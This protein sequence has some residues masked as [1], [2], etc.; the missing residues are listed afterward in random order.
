MNQIDL[1]CGI[2]Q[3]QAKQFIHLFSKAKKVSLQVGIGLERTRNGGS[4]IR[5]AMA[6]QLLS[7]NIGQLGQGIMGNYS[8]ALAKTADRL[9]RPDLL[10][11]PTRV[12]NLIDVADHILERTTKIPIKA[13]FIYNHN[14][15]ATHPD[16]N[17][18]CAA[19]SLEDVFIVGCDLSMTDSM[20]YA[21]IILPAASHFEHSEIYGA[22]G[23]ATIQH[24]NAVIDPVGEAWPN[25]EI[26]RQLS[27]RFGFDDDAFKDSD[28]ALLEQAFE[29]SRRPNKN[30]SSLTNNGIIMMQHDTHIWLSDMPKGDK[31]T[32]Y[33]E[34]LEQDYGYG[35]PRYEALVSSRPYQLITAASSQRTNAFFGGESGSMGLQMVDINPL[36]AQSLDIKTGRLVTL[37][38]HKGKVV[39]VANVTNDVKQ[40]I[41]S[42]DKGAW[43][44]ASPTAQNANALIDNQSKTD[45]GEGAA[46]YDTFVDIAL[47]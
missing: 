10:E 12:F 14:P 38:N 4:A 45:I 30:R 19:L 11:T 9:Q 33:S 18:M 7:G 31:I 42:T 40:G 16:Q 3:G 41:L 20:K 13:V 36:D 21:D 22:Y 25:T 29:V 15:V 34:A 37:L 43:R 35:L 17:K 1:I 8:P 27:Q 32:F 44:E 5:A 23:H 46:Y 26:F 6:L 28:E 2:D 24:A 47:V 39:L